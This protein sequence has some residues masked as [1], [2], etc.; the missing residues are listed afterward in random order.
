[1]Q[2]LCITKCPTGMVQTYVAAEQLETAGKALGYHIR[3]ETH[4]A[5]GIGGEFTP[6]QIDEAD[7]VVIASNTEVLKTTRFGNKKILVVSLEDA[8]VN[9]ESVLGRVAEEA[10]SYEDVKNQFPKILR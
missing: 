8:I 6:E 7:Y 5:Q 9:A 10:E 2:L 4:G 1:M 3:T